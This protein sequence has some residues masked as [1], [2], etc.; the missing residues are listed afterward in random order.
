MLFKVIFLKSEPSSE[1]QFFWH[2]CKEVTDHITNIQ[3]VRILS[4]FAV[5]FWKHFA[6]YSP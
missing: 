1:A 6:K 5:N 4:D 3:F 2:S